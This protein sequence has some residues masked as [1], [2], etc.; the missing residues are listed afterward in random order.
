M[1]DR[2]GK[3]QMTFW[4][5]PEEKEQIKE[6]AERAGITATELII[7]SVLGK[8]MPMMGDTELMREYAA[9]LGKIGLNLNQI[10]R[11]LNGGEMSYQIMDEVAEAVRDFTDL[12]FRVMMA[13]EDMCG[14][15]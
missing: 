10:A 14:G 4:V 9:Q 5:R 8:K 1:A 7:R 6:K 2:N 3:S 15:R 12:K 13:L 11:R